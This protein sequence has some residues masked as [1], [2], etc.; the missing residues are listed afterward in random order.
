MR[1][2][3]DR[4]LVPCGGHINSLLQKAYMPPSRPQTSI[5]FLEGGEAQKDGCAFEHVPYP[6][7]ATRRYFPRVTG[8]PGDLAGGRVLSARRRIVGE[9]SGRGGGTAGTAAPTCLASEG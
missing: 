5:G 7:L 6:P 2:I 8:R 1:M 4:R 9:I 3:L